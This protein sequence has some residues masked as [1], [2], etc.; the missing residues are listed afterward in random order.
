MNRVVSCFVSLNY[1]QPFGEYGF[2]FNGGHKIRKKNLM[3]N[4]F[5][6]KKRKKFEGAKTKKFH[7]H[8]VNVI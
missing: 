5:K 6:K 7:R 1:S 3:S 4:I 8:K 2:W